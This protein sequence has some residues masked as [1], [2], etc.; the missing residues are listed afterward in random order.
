MFRGHTIDIFRAR[1]GKTFHRPKLRVRM[2]ISDNLNAVKPLEYRVDFFVT[3]VKGH[4]PFMLSVRSLETESMFD[5]EPVLKLIAKEKA[6]T[7]S[8]VDLSRA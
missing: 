2:E 8:F 7:F 3:S 1:E 5:D 6:E 4:H